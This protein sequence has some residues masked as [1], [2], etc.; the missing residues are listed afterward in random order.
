[1]RFLLLIYRMRL[2]AVRNTLLQR[3]RHG[4][5][6]WCIVFLA[7]AMVDTVIFGVAPRTLQ[8]AQASA[9]V[10]GSV[11]TGRLFSALISF[12]NVSFAMLFLASFPL[13]IGTYTYKSDLSILLPTPVE[14][15]IVFAEKLLTG[16]IRQ[17]VLVIPLMGPYLLGLGVGLH[18]PPGFFLISAGILALMPIGP[19]CLGGMLTFVFLTLFPPARAK[20]LVTVGGAIVGSIFYLSQEIIWS[21]RTTINLGR[22]SNLVQD[23]SHQWL[24][25]LPP[26]WPASALTLASEHS[27][28]SALVYILCFGLLGAAVFALAVATALRTFSSG[29]ANFQEAN[30]VT[31][32]LLLGDATPGMQL[33]RRPVFGLSPLLPKEWLLFARDPQQWAA[34][35]MPLGVSVYFSYVLIFRYGSAQLPTGIR[36]LLAIAGMN[37]LISSM[38][39][40][41]S[42]TIINRESRTFIL[43]R[44]WPISTLAVLRDKFLSVYLP[45][46]FAFELLV[47]VIVI[48]DRLPPDLWLLGSVGTAL[49]CGTLVA[50]SMVLSLAF[51]RLDW[52]NITQISTWQAWL[53]SFI[54]GTAIGILEAA[55][56]ALGPVTA[57]A[58]AQVAAAAPIL[59][60]MGLCVVLAIS[61]G[62]ALLLFVWGP[63]RLGR[64][65]IR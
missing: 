12:F 4:A 7:V 48:G 18:L 42:L 15:G 35:I 62:V 9:A 20:T 10:P 50:W 59:T 11:D 23:F 46:L 39:A 52:T 55:L 37:F 51:P 22:A 31:E 38:V 5:F 13:T 1:M 32:P 65:E 64:I 6:G 34:L 41:L 24:A 27:T 47:V 61:G 19:T 49:F 40:P 54:G 2:A 8:L 44:T 36:F 25:Q 45:L 56:L 30:R 57:T 14:P 29:W 26:S 16:M 58:Y 63:R 33:V 17:Y 3:G 60:G 43:L 28:G 21:S 53:L